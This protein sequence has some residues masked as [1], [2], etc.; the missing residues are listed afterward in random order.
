VTAAEV[1]A[2]V[3]LLRHWVEAGECLGGQVF[4][5][6]DGWVLADLAVGQSGPARAASAGDVA[7]YYCAFKPV[8]A[9]CFARAVDAGE[10][11]LD[12]PVGRYLPGFDLPDRAAMSLR[13]LLNHTSGMVD[14]PASPYR[15]GYREMAALMA[16]RP[17]APHVWYRAPRYNDRVSWDVLAAVIERIYARDFAEVVEQLVSAVPELA[18]LRVRDPDRAR[19]ARCHRLTGGRFEPVDEAPDAKVFGT[20]NPAHGGFGTARDLGSLYAEIVECADGRGT[21]LG[22]RSAREFT[23][24]HSVIEFGLGMGQRSYGLGFVVDVREDGIGGSW[25]TNSFGHAGYV[26]RY[27]VVHGF[28]DPVHRIAVGLRLFSVG[29]KNNW[30]FHKLGAALSADLELVE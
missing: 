28:A 26:S 15:A 20:V 12:D 9:L 22:Q 16:S 19:Y 1:P 18:A 2:T 6:R 24:R 21:L 13:N 7:R 3:A 29:A 5:W 11:D 27:R 25:S 14:S 17:L 30:R 4:V 23:S 10:V 8:T